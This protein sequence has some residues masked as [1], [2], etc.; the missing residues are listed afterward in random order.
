MHIVTISE[1]D[2]VDKYVTLTINGSIME[3]VKLLS[4]PLDEN[5]YLCICVC[6]LLRM[7]PLLLFLF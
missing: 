3:A 2:V 6:L 7:A 5:Q 4:V 1:I